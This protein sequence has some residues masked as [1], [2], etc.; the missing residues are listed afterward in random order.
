MNTWYILLLLV[1]VACVL[2]MTQGTPVDNGAGRRQE[3][4]E[5]YPGLIG[6]R[7]VITTKNQ[8]STRGVV[9]IM[10]TS[11]GKISRPPYT[12]TRKNSTYVGMPLKKVMPT[13]QSKYGAKH[14]LT[15]T[16][17][18]SMADDDAP[19]NAVRII[20]DAAG[21]VKDVDI[22]K[23]WQSS[24]ALDERREMKDAVGKKPVVIP[25]GKNAP[26]GATD[27]NRILFYLG[28]G[29][30]VVRTVRG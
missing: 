7:V 27:P 20:V 25:A 24:D 4:F 14:V 21:T 9:T 19:S 5:A 17:T 26:P 10:V 3:S 12:L 28:A 29:G 8:P 2:T 23:Q 13:L 1:V 11:Q 22:P 6:K 30:K 16:D 18:S 15:H